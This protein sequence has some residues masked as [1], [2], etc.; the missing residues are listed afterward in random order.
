[1]CCP[2]TQRAKLP[3]MAHVRAEESIDIAAPADVVFALITDLARMPQWRANVVAAEWTDASRTRLRATTRL[4]GVSMEWDCEVTAL[5]APHHFSYLARDRGGRFEVEA[6][7]IVE[8]HPDGC[9]VVMRGAG[10]MP[11]GRI[12]GVAAPLYLRS[13]QR[14]NRR[15]LDK[16]KHLAEQGR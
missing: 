10:E 3:V 1:M 15:S 16:L 8:P 11:G 7:F 12:G 9:T 6:A 2:G 5:D 13:L 4:M 14:E